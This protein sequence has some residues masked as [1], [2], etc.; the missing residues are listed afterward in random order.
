MEKTIQEIK[1]EF[2]KAVSSAINAIGNI[3]K[4]D[5]ID[6]AVLGA[7]CTFIADQAADFCNQQLRK[8]LE[9]SGLDPELVQKIID[10]DDP[11]ETHKLLS[12]A[13]KERADK[14][15][16]DHTDNVFHVDFTKH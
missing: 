14:K 6:P 16:K 2:N 12:V 11:E 13:R 9:E 15:V 3:A 7:A 4:R 10:C 5:N 1:A 8:N